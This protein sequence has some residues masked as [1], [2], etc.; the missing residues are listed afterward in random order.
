MGFLLVAVQFIVILSGIYPHS[1]PVL[2][3]KCLGL[4]ISAV[5]AG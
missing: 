3:A 5:K 4:S 2:A 1:G